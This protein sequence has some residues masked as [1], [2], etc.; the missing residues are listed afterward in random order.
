MALTVLPP[1][2]CPGSSFVLYGACP[3]DTNRACP[4]HLLQT[5]FQ[6]HLHSERFLTALL[7]RDTGNVTQGRKSG[8]QQGAPRGSLFS[9][10]GHECT[11]LSSPE[12]P[13]PLGDHPEHTSPGRSGAPQ[14]PEPGTKRFFSSS[15]KL[16]WR[17][18]QG[19]LRPPLFL[20]APSPIPSP[21]RP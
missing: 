14:Y 21:T 2:F 17:A 7:G 1:G 13:W 6:C 12:G 19:P 8:S 11:V 3:S 4:L 10:S 20:A 15:T 16:G 9:F 5:L 18:S